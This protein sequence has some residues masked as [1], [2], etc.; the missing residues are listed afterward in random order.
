LA[1]SKDTLYTYRLEGTDD[2][3]YVV[4]KPTEN[5]DILGADLPKKEQK[6]IR[7]TFPDFSK[8]SK[9]ENS[10]IFKREIKRMK[11]GVYVWVNGYLT[12]IT[13]KHYFALT[14]WRLKESTS[15]Y[16][17][18]TKTQ[19]DI[20]YFF[21]LCDKDP[22]CVGAIIFSL[23]RLGKSELFQAEMFADALLSESGTYVVQALNDDEAK[24]IFGKTHFAN[25]HLHES[26]PVWRH[27]HD[28][29]ENKPLESLIVLNRH[30][31]ADSIVWKNADGYVSGDAINFMVKP[32]KLA[33][34]QGKKL[35]RAALDEFASLKPIK[36]MTLANWHS[37]AVAQ[38][39]E[40]FGSRV[41]GK[42]WLI[43]T[44]ENMTSES[45]GDAKEIF[46][47]SA[48]DKKDANGFT[49]STFKRMFI[50]YYLGGRGAEFI[51]EYGNP[52]I[53]E[54]K[55]WYANKLAGLTEGARQLFR[56]QNPETMKD[57]FA[58]IDGDG[59]ELDNAEKWEARLD[60]IK[61]NRLKIPYQYVTLSYE[62]GEV[63]K[64]QKKIT[65]PQ[66]RDKYI[67]IIEDVKPNVT[68]VVGVDGTN[69]SKQ[70]SET[71]KKKSKFA[72]V[73]VKLFEGIDF[74]NYMTV[75]NIAIIPD[76][77]EDLIKM[78]Y[79]LTIMYNK[80][81]KC[82]VMAEGNVGIGDA[83]VGYF[84]NRGALKLIR[85]QPKY[86]GTESKEVKNRYTVYID[87]HVSAET[88]RLINIWVRRHGNNEKSARVIED[89][90]KIGK[91][92]TDFG[93]AL[94]VALLGCGNFDP[95]TQKTKKEIKRG[96]RR[97]QLVYVGGVW[98][99][100]YV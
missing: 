15:D 6:W 17:I 58:V 74:E 33:G 99:Y 26:L 80:Y 44:A 78:V 50:P 40:D 22:K 61:E 11:Y 66:D 36:D 92:N 68:Y 85:K 16:L 14:H 65:N 76:R 5:H 97:Q 42:V 91:E 72:I 82:S 86:G 32:T 13:G 38:C 53:E 45:L 71:T 27:K 3:D 51:D 28:K 75:A 81:D 31:T 19:R 24:D 96:K 37:K 12:Y 63:L 67:E 62:N 89:C 20:F 54:A 98:K 29:K 88:L 87:E 59:L 93:S 46:D 90:L 30:S 73:V 8:T 55:K 64:T 95:E 25:E 21:D 60:W 49:P 43:A 7:P 23:K 79:N 2:L 70:T 57:V 35:K 41:L 10:E 77:M 4:Y 83:I 9:S 48:E 56:R 47:G 39:T 69:T 52:K 1:K 18:Y 84:E 34:I 94:R 100:E